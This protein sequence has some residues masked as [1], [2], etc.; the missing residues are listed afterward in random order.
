MS[1]TKQIDQ[2]YQTRPKPDGLRFG[3]VEVTT[4]C[5]YRC[6]GCY[7][8]RRNHLNHG[9]MS[10][11]QAVRVLDLCLDYIGRELETMDILGGEPLLWPHL[12]EYIEVLLNKGIQPWIFTN[13]A[14]A[15]PE[16]ASWLW[17][18]Q[19]HV[20]GK[21]NVDPCD[22]SQHALQAEMILVEIKTAIETEPETNYLI[23]NP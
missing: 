12:K 18:R 20:S 3:I 8:V 13:M 19:V 17:D 2:R 4:H 22:K 16:L 15:T 1:S 23:D 21:L 7:M 14:P 9:A 10:L 5:Q 11:E 6:P